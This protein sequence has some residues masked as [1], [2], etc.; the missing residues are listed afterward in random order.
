MVPELLE[1]PRLQPLAEAPVSGGRMTQPR[2]LERMPLHARPKHQEDGVHG[3]SIGHAWVVAAQRMLGP[4][5]Q[6]GLE[7]GPHF[8]R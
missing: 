8:V 1:D 3:T 7:L 6:Q 5:W 4:L 2:G